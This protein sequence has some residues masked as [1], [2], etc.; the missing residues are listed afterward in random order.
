M[1]ARRRTRAVES[2]GEV[3]D[4]GWGLAFERKYDDECSFRS[5]TWADTSQ[6]FSDDRKKFVCMVED[7][8]EKLLDLDMEP[9]PESLRWTSTFKD[10]GVATL[11]VGGDVLFQRDGKRS[12]R[13][14]T[15]GQEKDWGAGG[16]VGSF[17]L[18]KVCPW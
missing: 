9:K 3:E 15:N 18:R 1:G 17:T 12:G 10:E 16:V 14:R 13:N 6:L 4:Q 5:T 2:R 8:I 11:K 7:I